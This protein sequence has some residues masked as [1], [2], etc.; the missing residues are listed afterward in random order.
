[1]HRRILI[2][3]RREQ[4]GI[5]IAELA[6]RIGISISEY[7]DVE[8]Y[9]DELTMVLPLKNA[10]SLAAILGFDL[11]TLL[12]AG[13]LAGRL[14]PINKPRHVILAEARAKLGVSTTK[15]AEDIGFD[16]GVVHRIENDSRA[17]EP[18]P[19]DFL[20]I[21]ASYLKLDPIDL[22]DDPSAYVR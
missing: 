22:L 12:G 16:E 4:L 8:L 13:S 11:G 2:K 19:Y 1:V 7:Q 20:Q 21:V 9:E 6:R 14:S 17:L 5:G 3:Q 10:R 15:M 18:Y